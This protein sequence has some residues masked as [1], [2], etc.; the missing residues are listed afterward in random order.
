[1]SILYINIY[2]YIYVCVYTYSFKYIN[3]FGQYK[4][5][6]VHMYILSICTGIVTLK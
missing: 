6:A 3:E 1:M 5:Y 2:I 4:Y